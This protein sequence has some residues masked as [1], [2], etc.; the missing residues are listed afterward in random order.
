[1][2]AWLAVQYGCIAAAGLAS[3]WFVA[4]K[5]FPAAMRALRLRGAAWLLRTGPRPWKQALARR[6]APAASAAGSACGG[7]SSDC[8]NG[9]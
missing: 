4:N 1:M 6:L 3:A 5:Q 8:E 9:R 2:N 7:C